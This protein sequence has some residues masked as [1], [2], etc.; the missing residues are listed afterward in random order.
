M[1]T[2]MGTLWST[3]LLRFDKGQDDV[4]AEFSRF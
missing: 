1:G 3:L 2:L 4:L